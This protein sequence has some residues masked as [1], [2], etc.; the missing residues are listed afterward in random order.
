MPIINSLGA[1]A[2]FKQ[3]L[4]YN[5]Y[6]VTFENSGVSPTSPNVVLLDGL[7][8]SNNLYLA[9]RTNQDY[10]SFVKA[11]FDSNINLPNLTYDAFYPYDDSGT[12]R[13][14]YFLEIFK[15]SN[16]IYIL[17]IIDDP[18]ISN[19]VLNQTLITI[20]NTNNAVLTNYVD[21][22]NVAGNARVP[23]SAILN[24]SD[25]TISGRIRN[26]TTTESFFINNYTNDGSST[27]WRKTIKQGI[28]EKQVLLH[29]FNSTTNRYL[30]STDTSIF[31]LS[32][33]GNVVSNVKT[34]TV[35]N[36]NDV[37]FEIGTS[38]YYLIANNGAQLLKISGNTKI[39]ERSAPN[40]ITLVSIHYN[41]NNV[42]V[43]SRT[44]NQDYINILNLDSNSGNI[45]WQKNINFVDPSTPNNNTQFYQ[46]YTNDDNL[47]VIG[48]AE[49]NNYA[50]SFVIKMPE[51][52]NL[53][54][55]SYPI[56][57]FILNIENGNLTYNSSNNINITTTANLVSNNTNSANIK[58]L[59][60]IA[61]TTNNWTYNS[62]EI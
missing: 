31:N 59:N 57:N 34:F 8:E 11:N 54:Y 27:S 19:N 37:A 10:A 23:I 39:F 53:N 51:D 41:N 33:N 16:K 9:G 52:A 48:A 55:T 30:C 42:Y 5:G 24:N 60:L 6:V 4:Y 7:T 2:T 28:I 13:K 40:N 36:I 38:N 50:A 15:N 21:T 58:S 56:G 25:I 35:N 43:G 3:E 49:S 61:N 26:L 18:T 14:T 47:Y 46:L 44:S 1:L 17:G 22:S 20:D 32:S 12:L 62:R 45:Q 29:N